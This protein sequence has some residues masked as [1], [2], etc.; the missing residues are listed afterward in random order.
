MFNFSAKQVMR[1]HQNGVDI[2][3]LVEAA[4]DTVCRNGYENIFYI[5][6]GGTVL[7]ANQ[8]AAIAKQAGS[9]IPL[10]VENAADFCVVGNPHFGK[11]SVVVMESI[12]G[13]TKEVVEAVRIAKKAGA[14]V[15]GYV[16][17]KGTFLADNS[18]YLISTAGGGYYFWYTVTLRFM[19]NAGEFEK[20]DKF[21]S[22]IVSMPENAVE[23]YKAADEKAEVFAEAY[24]DEPIQYLI[25]SG[26]L[27]DWAVCYGMC[28]LEEM[29]WMRTRPISASNFFH[30][31]LEVIDRNTSVIL[32]KGEDV[33]RPL[34]ERVENFVN[35]VSAKVTVFDT[36][37]Y[38]LEGISDEFR[39][40]LSPIVI[41][42]AF[43]RVSVHLEYK[44]R[45][46]LAIRRYYR[47]LDY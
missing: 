38:P 5:G 22:E 19:K 21:F 33:T 37:D 7:Y 10:Y 30:G 23:I 12:S 31:T 34:M 28:I 44:R 6:I 26:N 15:I 27:E 14:R 9:K 42:C 16:E 43:Q 45:H 35:K 20:Y 17:K 24:Q 18:D 41:R 1:E 11:N 29:Q 4:V 32:I 46:P 39:G 8:M 13:D 2:I 3:P 40:L 47:R 25:G 36:K